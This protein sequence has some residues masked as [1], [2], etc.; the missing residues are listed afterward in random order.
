MK[1]M[2]GGVVRNNYSVLVIWLETRSRAVVL[3]GLG[4]RGGRW[5]R[6]GDIDNVAPQ[7]IFG[8]VWRHFCLSQLLG[9]SVTHI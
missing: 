1:G 9:R 3:N 7:G 5:W 6:Q 8:N 4:L 2:N